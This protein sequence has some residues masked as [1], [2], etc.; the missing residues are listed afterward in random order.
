MSLTSQAALPR[1][2]SLPRSARAAAAV[3]AL[4]AA[5]ILILAL[6]GAFDVPPSEPAL[7]LVLAIA[8]PPAAFFLAASLVRPLRRAVLAIDP[9]LLVEF[10]AWRILGGVFLVVMAFGHLPGFFAYPA[11][12][13]DVAIGITAPFIALQLRK[14]PD[15]LK[16]NRFRT[17]HLLGLADFVIAAGTGIAARNAIPG[18]VGEVTA[19]AMGQLPLVLIPAFI[20]PVFIILHLI[21]LMQAAEAR[22]AG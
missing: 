15:F 6:N 8:I 20:V 2:R 13:G 4:W 10:Q 19:G 9:V 21:S 5:G 22:R 3:L 17:F 14:H 16:S 1:S 7:P 18:L 12:L 11:G